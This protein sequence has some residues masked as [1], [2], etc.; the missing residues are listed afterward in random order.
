MKLKELHITSFRGLK[1]I[2]LDNLDSNI[3]L[4]VGVNGAG[5]SSILDSISLLMTWY[6]ARIQNSKG[7]G[8]D[9]PIDDISMFSIDG[10]SIELTFDDSTNWKLYRSTKYKKGDKSDL[11]D[12]NRK[13]SSLRENIDKN[14][15]TCIPIVAHY[16]VNRIIPNKYPRTPI[17]KQ[18]S[19]V[20]DT[21]KNSL[22][23]GNL[24]SDF[25]NWFRLSE[26]YENEIYKETLNS[27][28]D[29]GLNAVREAMKSIFPEYTQMKVGR[30]PNALYLTKGEHKLKL[31]QLSDGEK[32]YITLVCDIARRLAIA[33]PIGNPLEGEGIVLIDE[34]DLHLHPSW[35]ISVISKLKETFKNVQ[36]FITTHSPIV[37]SDAEG[38][39]FSVK[40]GLVNR[41][42]TYGKL[43]SN[44][45][46]S[47]FGISMARNLYVQSL[48]ESAYT[49]LDNGN[50]DAFNTTYSELET[51]LGADDIDL[52]KLRIEKFRRERSRS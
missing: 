16:G 49:N 51:I 9:I 27:N 24:F 50:S 21:Y 7:R 38:A 37:A 23:A 36:F 33:N 43:S 20:L 52:A 1:N 46:S 11:I 44:I 25:Y 6:I 42:N 19:I 5:K 10:C 28:T 40:D 31:N 35:Q 14:I 29:R 8:K 22:N 4:F 47:V 3:N 41:E 32:C 12:L 17:S 26:D 2:E 39:V 45:L 15:E 48:I 30:R 34:V 13:V 18:K